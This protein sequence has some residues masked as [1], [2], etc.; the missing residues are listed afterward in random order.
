LNF[1]LIHQAVKIY[2]AVKLHSVQFTTSSCEMQLMAQTVF[3]QK[4]HLCQCFTILHVVSVTHGDSVP[5]LGPRDWD[6]QIVCLLS[7]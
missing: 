2:T 7:R 6:T 5:P 1:E 3:F 4:P